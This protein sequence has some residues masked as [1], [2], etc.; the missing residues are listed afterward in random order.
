MTLKVKEITCETKKLNYH[1]YIVHVGYM[2]S[3]CVCTLN[4]MYTKIIT[5]TCTITCMYI[6]HIELIVNVHVQ[7]TVCM[8]ILTCTH[9]DIHVH[10]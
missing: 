9:G 1:V 6:N 3:M 5:C 8:Y 4:Q 2:Y 10:I 7:Y